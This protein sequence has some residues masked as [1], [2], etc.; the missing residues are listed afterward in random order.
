M[1]YFIHYRGLQS[2]WIGYNDIEEDEEAGEAKWRWVSDGTP[3]GYVNWHSGEP[4]GRDRENCGEIMNKWDP[5]WEEG[6]WND[7]PCGNPAPFICGRVKR[8]EVI[9]SIIISCLK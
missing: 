2:A 5:L 9:H 7:A 8:G 4:N 6:K 3:S 1:K